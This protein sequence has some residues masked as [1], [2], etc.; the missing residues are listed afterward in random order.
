MAKEAPKPDTVAYT[1]RGIYLRQGRAV[2]RDGFDPTI[3]GQPL[4]A[5]HRSGSGKA[6]ITT[7]QDKDTGQPV[8]FFTLQHDFEFIYLVRETPIDSTESPPT[9]DDADA[10]VTMTVCVSYQTIG[11]TGITE[12]EIRELGEKSSLFLAWPYWREY[13]QSSLMRMGLPVFNVPLLNIQ[14]QA[15]PLP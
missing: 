11:E 14:M 4:H 8:Q 10:A 2:L 5:I 7:A 9:L 15:E 12:Q 3:P 13:C 6:F 1:L